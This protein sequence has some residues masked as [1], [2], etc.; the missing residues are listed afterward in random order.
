[1]RTCAISNHACK[2][3]TNGS[4]RLTGSKSWKIAKGPLASRESGAPKTYSN[5]RLGGR[6]I[7]RLIPFRTSRG[8][9]G[10]GLKAKRAERVDDFGCSLGIFAPRDRLCVILDISVEIFVRQTAHRH[11]MKM[12]APLTH[13]LALRATTVRGA[14][15][16]GWRH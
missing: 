6:G 15:R 5:Q 13:E 11:S 12:E 8:G 2:N 9:A 4:L 16:L 7:L 10:S 1:M 14:D 3:V